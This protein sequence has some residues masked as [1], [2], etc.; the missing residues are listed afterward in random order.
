MSEVECERPTDPA[1]GE[2]RSVTAGRSRAGRRANDPGAE[3]DF[4]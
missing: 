1:R 4:G 3:R 2:L